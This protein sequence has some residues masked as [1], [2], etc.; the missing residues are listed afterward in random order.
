[1]TRP[2]WQGVVR[3]AL[4]VHEH[5]H[6][7]DSAMLPSCRMTSDMQQAEWVSLTVSALT[8]QLL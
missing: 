7:T 3:I 5:R 2:G 4:S 8:K 6:Q 1:M